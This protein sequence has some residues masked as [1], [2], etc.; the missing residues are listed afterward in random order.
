VRD[1]RFTQSI[2]EALADVR[3]ISR[4]RSLEVPDEGSATL[5]PWLHLGHFHFSS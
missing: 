2:V 3:G 4:E 5:A 1:L